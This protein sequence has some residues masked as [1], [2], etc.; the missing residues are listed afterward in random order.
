M[1]LIASASAQ[2]HALLQQ[3]QL[4]YQIIATVDDGPQAGSGVAQAIALERAQ[5]K[6][7]AGQWQSH[8]N[9]LGSSDAVHGAI[10]AAD[11][12]VSVGGKALGSPTNHD[13]A[14]Q[15]LQ[16]LSGTRHTVVTAHCCYLPAVNGCGEQEALAVALAQ[17]TML[18]LSAEQIDAY[19]ASGEGLGKAG[20]YA[21]QGEADPFVADIQG[22][23]DTVIGLNVAVVKRLYRQVTGHYPEEVQ[24]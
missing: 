4:R 22:D 7:R 18:P 14:R 16:N 2:R 6:A 1:I 24:Q 19:V 8:A 12:V 23:R 5:A 13:E 9:E 3:A 17:V 20:G 11:T 21:I 15:M 10:L